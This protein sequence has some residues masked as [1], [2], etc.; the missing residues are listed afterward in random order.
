MLEERRCPKCGSTHLWC[1]MI[2]TG[3]PGGHKRFLPGRT[4][5]RD[6]EERDEAEVGIGR[7]PEATVPSFGSYEDRSQDPELAAAGVGTV[8]LGVMHEACVTLIHSETLA[9]RRSA[10]TALLPYVDRGK[11]LSYLLGL[12]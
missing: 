12:V 3:M 1:E 9:E 7:R 2:D 4:H 8:T 10:L 6:C 5:C 11:D